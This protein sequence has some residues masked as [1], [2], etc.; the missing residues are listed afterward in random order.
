[1]QSLRSQHGV[2]KRVVRCEREDGPREGCLPSRVQGLG[3]PGGATAA[4]KNMGALQIIRFPHY[5]NL[6]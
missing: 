6:M 5:D 1:M 2:S 4:A 3:G